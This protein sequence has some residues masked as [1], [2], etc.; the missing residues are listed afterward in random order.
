MAAPTRRRPCKSLAAFGYFSFFW[1][2]FTVIS[3]LSLYLSS[4]TSNF[5]TR[6][7]WRI[8]SADGHGD[9]VFLRHHAIDGNV[10]AGLEA[11]VAVG[12]NAHQPAVFGD[13]HAG[14]FILAHDFERVADLVGGGHGDGI[15]D[16]A[17]LRAFHLV[18]FVGLLLDAQVAMNNAEP[19]LLR[20]RNRH[21]RFGDGVH[22]SADDGNVQ[23]DV[24][25]ELRLGGGGCGNYVGACG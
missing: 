20:Q 18:D 23:A 17:A 22:G 4:T 21:V 3:P 6:C 10:E 8:S 14:N 2:S 15:D 24:T 13:G 9:E 1:I 12:E 16:H 11:Q 25:G 19:A 7:S 5:S